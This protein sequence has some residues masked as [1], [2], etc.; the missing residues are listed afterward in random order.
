MEGSS[1][2]DE[3]VRRTGKQGRWK[4]V[5]R[6][7]AWLAT[8]LATLII[9]LVFYWMW[10]ISRPPDIKLATDAE[11]EAAIDP[12]LRSI[13]LPKA[14]NEKARL[15]MEHL[16]IS[17]GPGPGRKFYGAL[18]GSDLT[19]ARRYVASL[20][21]V[22][23][24]SEKAIALGPWKWGRNSW[25]SGATSAARFDRVLRLLNFL[26]TS[27][28]IAQ[29][30][31]D[32]RSLSRRTLLWL[33]MLK[34]VRES[35]GGGANISFGSTPLRVVGVVLDEGKA[36][37]SELVSLLAAIPPSETV[38]SNLERVVALAYRIDFLPM[39]KSTE[40]LRKAISN[41]D[42]F[43][44]R[45]NGGNLDVVQTVRQTSTVLAEYLA[46]LKSRNASSQGPAE[47]RLMDLVMTGIP[48]VV[49]TNWGT[50]GGD[51][52]PLEVQASQLAF[53]HWLHRTPNSLGILASRWLE[54]IVSRRWTYLR[55]RTMTELTRLQLAM[56]IYRLRHQT[57]PK[58][59]HDLISDHILAKIPIDSYTHE[60]LHYLANEHVI[61]SFGPDG[62]D[63]QGTHT[64]QV[65]AGPE[66]G[67]E[68]TDLYIRL[69]ET[70][71]ERARAPGRAFGRP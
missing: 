11:I 35:D 22:L 31:K 54:T 7:S 21:G 66:A 18:T 58:D 8:T 63:N 37:E 20:S 5:K 48:V 36:T 46:S 10:V 16:L 41:S 33:R 39:F 47:K 14:S 51:N 3:R 23:R 49:P 69:G 4:K 12:R 53:A 27:A 62:V 43:G 6:A 28:R 26:E 50:D 42:P 15:A 71:A 9:L 24:D 59:I 2:Y 17:L 67:S 40:A 29:A 32:Y 52:N 68:Q 25:T 30:D 13:Q 45:P 61:Y 34:A 65:T 38:D 19:S 60:P 57:Y 44:Y 55:D 56:E 1:R 70:L 64:R